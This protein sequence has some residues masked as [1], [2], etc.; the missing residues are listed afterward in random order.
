MNYE[1]DHMHS[2][3]ELRFQKTSW[4]QLRGNFGTLCPWSNEV[5]EDI[6]RALDKYTTRVKNGLDGN[7]MDEVVSLIKSISKGKLRIKFSV[8]DTAHILNIEGNKDERIRMK[9]DN[10]ECV[11][12]VLDSGAQITA[13][14]SAFFDKLNSCLLYTSPSPRDRTRSRMPSSA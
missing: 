6:A 8:K 5:K 11:D 1:F 4:N 2:L 13:I 12:A 9:F 14:S 7:K 3:K 10:S